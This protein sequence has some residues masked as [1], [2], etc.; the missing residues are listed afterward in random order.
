MTQL[1][2]FHCHL[3]LFP[4]PA[5]AFQD[6][7]RGGCLTVTMTTTPRAWKQNRLWAAG[8][9][10]IVP[11]LGLHPEL[12]ATHEAEADLLFEALPGVRIVGEIGL[13]GN[14]RNK[15]SLAAQSKIFSLIVERAAV[16]TGSVLSIHSRAAVTEVLS[17]LRDVPKSSRLTPVLHWFAGSLRQLETAIDMGCMFSVNGAM[18]TSARTRELIKRIP[19]DGLL[20]ESDAPFRAGNS[21]ASRDHDIQLALDGIAQV[22][23]IESAE[24]CDQIFRNAMRVLQ[25]PVLG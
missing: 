14:S 18:L 8:K 22:R 1:V 15:A 25:K 24:L 17:I 9:Q 11:A 6:S 4:D 16:H 7:D 10:H 23:E 2:D 21:V 13:D 20:T 3:D 5:K 19:A 12:V